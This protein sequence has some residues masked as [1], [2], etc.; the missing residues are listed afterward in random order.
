ML[1]NGIQRLKLG[2]AIA[3]ACFACSGI[4]SS[5]YAADLGGDCCADLEE[6]VAELEA[7]TARKGNR[8]VSLT[9]SGWVAEQVMWW[10]DGTESNVYVSGVGTTLASHFKFSGA[11]QITPDWSAGYVIHVEA[12]TEDPLTSLDQNNDD[13]GSGVRVHQ[14][15][16]FLKSERLGKVSVGLLSSASDN[17]AI[18]VDGSGSLVPANWVLFDNQAMRLR[19]NG[20]LM[21]QTWGDLA[22]CQSWGNANLGAAGDCGGFAGPQNVVR[23]DSPTFGGFSISAAW[24]EDDI[25]D[26]AGRYAG[27]FNGIKLAVSAAYFE[28]TDI[29]N[30]GGGDKGSYWEIGGYIEHVPTG[31]FAYGA[32]GADIDTPYGAYD[33]G[34]ETWYVKAGLRRRM[35]SLGHTVLYGEYGVRNDAIDCE[36]N[37]SGPNRGPEFD[38]TAPISLNNLVLGGEMRQWGLGIVQEIDAAAMSLWI[39]YRH[40]EGEIDCGTNSCGRGYDPASKVEFDDFD[41]VK[42]G[43]LINF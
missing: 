7:T 9:I 31:L 42:F 3:A 8:K 17:A 26:V 32:Y 37:G 24:G 43:A 13:G 25:W 11:A 28:Q 16:W 20:V 33:F 41:L 2:A 19:H 35:T 34:A 27:E 23:Y 4:V 30:T 5:A 14:S 18:L 29:D 22:H 12:G 1:N 10:D 6:R 21:P 39:S 15:Y 38:C 36:T 40:F